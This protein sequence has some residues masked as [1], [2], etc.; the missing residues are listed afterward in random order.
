[1]IYQLTRTPQGLALLVLFFPWNRH[2]KSQGRFHAAA[3]ISDRD[4]RPHDL[5]QR[6]IDRDRINLDRQLGDFCR[7]LLFRHQ[8]RASLRTPLN[9]RAS[10]FRATNSPLALSRLVKYSSPIILVLSCERLRTA[11]LRWPSPAGALVA[12]G[13]SPHSPQNQRPLAA[14]CSATVTIFAETIQSLLNWS[15]NGSI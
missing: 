15:G 4:R 11:P 7:R 14:P 10:F 6:R 9:F 8:R 3:D 12:I 5:S 13:F 2:A 1:M